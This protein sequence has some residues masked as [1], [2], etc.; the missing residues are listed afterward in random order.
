MSDQLSDG[1]R[2]RILTILDIYTRECLALQVGQ[3][4]TGSHV[5]NVLTRLVQERD[6]PE[7]I[8]CDNGSEFTSKVMDQWAWLNDIRL[9]F[10]TPGKPTENA[11][12]ESF[13]GRVR[14]ECLNLHWFSSLDEARKRL[15][16]WKAEYNMDRP[17]SSLGNISPSEYA[18]NCH[19]KKEST[20]PLKLLELA[21]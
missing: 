15:S 11:Y 6:K 13:N 21:V 12:I 18:T 9:D 2:Y 19:R 16:F 20:N 4:L 5:S 1:R 17:H 8:H 3:R 7:Y 14:Q 10:S